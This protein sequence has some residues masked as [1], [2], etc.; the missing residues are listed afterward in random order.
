MNSMFIVK[1]GDLHIR[2]PREMDHH[3]AEQIREEADNVI[4]QGKVKN[5]VFDFSKTT[6]MDSAGIGVMVGRYKKISCFGGKVIAVHMNGRIMKM[7][8]LSGMKGMIEI[9]Q[10]G[11]TK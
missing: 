10:A 6:F 5:I 2:M 7:I 11:A 8:Q 4:L 3:Q 9:H 1:N